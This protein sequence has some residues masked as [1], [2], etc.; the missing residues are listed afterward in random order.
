VDNAIEAMADVSTTT[1]TV[2]TRAAGNKVEI[3]FAD[4][5]KGISEDTLPKLFHEQIKESNGLGMG[6]L[7]AHTIVQTH[8]GEIRVE[9]TGPA[10]TSVVVSLPIETQSA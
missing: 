9:F 5:G 7:M 1:L 2:S 4:T 6:L 8:G 3:V 10:G